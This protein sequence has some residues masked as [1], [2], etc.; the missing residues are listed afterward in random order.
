MN[1]QKRLEK[2]SSQNP[3]DPRTLPIGLQGNEGLYEVVGELSWPWND[4]AKMYL[5]Y[6]IGEKSRKLK[7]EVKQDV[8][9]HVGI[10]T[11]YVLRDAGSPNPWNDVVS[12]QLWLLE[13][14]EGLIILPGAGRKEKLRFSQIVEVVDELVR[15]VIGRKRHAKRRYRFIAH[16]SQAEFRA[17]LSIREDVADGWLP[18][19]QRQK[20]LV[21]ARKEGLYEYHDKSRNAKSCLVSIHDTVLLSPGKLTA[22]GKDLDA[23]KV[24][25]GDDWI[26]RMDQLFAEQPDLYLDYA[27]HD[28]WI[29]ATWFPHFLEFVKELLPQE[30]SI[31]V[32]ASQLGQWYVEDRIEDVEEGL[33]GKEL[34]G[35]YDYRK[36]RYRTTLELPEELLHYGLRAYHGGRNEVFQVGVFH[37]DV[38]DYDLVSAYPT[39][40]LCLDDI[41]WQDPEYGV[42]INDLQPNDIGFARV[43]FAFKQN[44]WA[45]MFP[46]PAG[47]RGLIF[48]RTGT[49]TLSLSEVWTAHHNG[50]LE[51]IELQ[52][53]VRYT[54]R[55][56]RALADALAELVVARRSIPEGEKKGLR[57]RLLKLT[58]NSIYGKTAQGIR[59]KSGFDLE[60][61]LK[62]NT[63]I[64]KKLPRG[65]LCA[66]L[67]AASITGICRSLVG[68]YIHNLALAD[69]RV[70]SVTT[71]GFMLRDEV[72]EQMLRGNGLPLASWVARRRLLVTEVEE[73]LLEQ[74]H[75]V[76]NGT[77]L[78]IKNRMYWMIDHFKEHKKF[79]GKPLVARGGIQ[80]PQGMTDQ[81]AIEH[82]T[83]LFREKVDKAPVASWLPMDEYISADADFIK[84]VM[85]RTV[86]W[87]YD[88]KR[89][90]DEASVRNTQLYSLW[91]DFVPTYNTLPW[92]R[93]DDY[94]EGRENRYRNFGG[95][96][97][98]N[99]NKLL[100]AEEVEAFCE[101]EKLRTIADGKEENL[102]ICLAFKVFKALDE[103][104]YK[105]SEISR[106]ITVIDVPSKEIA[107]ILRGR[108]R[109]IKKIPAAEYSD[110]VDVFEWIMTGIDHSVIR[111]VRKIVFS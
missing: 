50:M 43:K 90:I 106:F 9:A 75:F 42:A 18:I 34:K 101:Y 38:F 72:P 88:L 22:L 23:P 67:I 19:D 66:P 77:T 76:N 58:S 7:V 40:V 79:R 84:E 12:I 55:D 45:P 35:H 98:N 1:S 86:N 107:D 64:R 13:L 52:E 78:V 91:D 108:S 65:K 31:P 87:D 62:K 73:P 96:E 102:R 36:G 95:V 97:K 105:P 27:M 37:G 89:R 92:E 59:E 39:A 3:S 109:G 63:S 48:P 33:V 47:E 82:M 57:D 17:G 94:I 11:E 70:L 5:M 46:V 30:E 10:D 104:G 15:G 16:F 2:E 41:D 32:S 29:C 25:L 54:R 83:G 71:D 20:S 74:K 8:V 49:T 6:R 110:L 28:A 51:S 14:N 81:E 53:C 26:E 85:Q 68:E 103:L 100:T 4:G 80:T 24:E 99:R 69:L 111:K 60:A 61:S 44:V 56:T 93:L 21:T